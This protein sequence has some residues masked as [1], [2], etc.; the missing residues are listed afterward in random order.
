M[1]TASVAADSSNV[2]PGLDVEPS[3]QPVVILIHGLSRSSSSMN[4]MASSLQDAGYRVCTVDYPSRKHSIADLTEK[5]LAPAVALCIKDAT[6]PVNFVTHSLGG[7]IVRQLAATGLVGNVGRV[8]MLGPPNHGSELVDAMVGWSL[9]RWINGPAGGE[10][11][12]S[13]TSFA[14]QVGPAHFQVGIIAGKL[15][16]NWIN[17]LI[18][19]G[20]DDG[21]VS[22]ESA[23]LDGMQDYVVVSATHPFLMK[24]RSAIAQVS[25]FLST[26]CF[27]HDSNKN[28]MTTQVCSAPE[29]DAQKD[30]SSDTDP[31]DGRK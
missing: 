9:F 23:K 13:S 1:L 2:Q 24:D 7:I 3:N 12:T 18:I 22:L 11:G 30:P 17:S 5:Y 26:G 16:I 14:Q 8:V 29:P 28:I 19:P 31:T 10:L 27:S 4:R 20:P 6:G 21:K 15:S 25:R